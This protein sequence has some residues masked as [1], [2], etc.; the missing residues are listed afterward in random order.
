MGL[1]CSTASARLPELPQPSLLP[2]LPVVDRASEAAAPI[3]ELPSTIL[4][5]EPAHVVEPS[6]PLPDTVETEVEELVQPVVEAVEEVVESTPAGSK[7]EQAQ[8]AGSGGAAGSDAGTAHASAAQSGEAPEPASGG[9]L[10]PAASKTVRSGGG[11]TGAGRQ[12]RRSS[13][14]ARW[15]HGSR[16]PQP[17]GRARAIRWAVSV[18]HRRLRLRRSAADR[19]PASRRG[20][21]P[22]R[23]RRPDDPEDRAH[24]SRLGLG[25]ARGAA[26]PGARLRRALARGPTPRAALERECKRLLSDVGALE[27]ALLPAVPARVGSLST[28]VAYRSAAG[29]GAGG[30]FYDAFE[31]AEGRAAIL[32]GDVSGHGEEALGR[33]GSMRGRCA[34][35]PRGGQSPRG[36][37]ASATRA[38]R[39]E[40]GT[41][42][43][44]S[45]SRFTIRPRV[46]RPTPGPVIHRPSWWASP[47]TS[48]S[49]PPPPRRS[50]S[51][52]AGAATDHR[53]VR[54]W[55]GRLLLH[56][57]TDRGSRWGRAHRPRT[58]HGHRHEPTARRSGRGPGG[59]ADRR[60][61]KD[62]GRYDRPPRSRRAGGG[63][64]APR[65][66]EL[67]LEEEEL[68]L[69]LGERFPT[70]CG[71]AGARRAAL[72]EARSVAADAGA[73]VLRVTLDDSTTRVGAEPPA[74]AD[75][76][77]EP[78]LAVVDFG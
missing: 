33:T 14:G 7:G 31:L 29:L 22:R 4:K 28:S 13:S 48:R 62:D 9:S 12:R 73:A 1:A 65:L 55:I 70:A 51:A 3:L 72:E 50:G 71:V 60:H 23:P 43:Q 63:F 2:R 21:E 27:R 44:P 54:A 38:W 24:R 61:R 69:G 20:T 57:R 58:A 64:V 39:D 19:P 35:L 10:G 26:G 40:P 67:E 49:P 59:A 18:R 34:R 5:R 78:A 30:D 8:S 42:S 25:G 52:C 45:W 6:Q 47:L 74:E 46:P 36:A 66:E 15:P 53:A 68:E 56:R 76:P 17:P 37:L 11:S 16:N 77:A 75:R 32:V 41:A